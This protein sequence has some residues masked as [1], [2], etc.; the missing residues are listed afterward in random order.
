MIG[1]VVDERGLNSDYERYNVSLPFVF[2]NK[3]KADTFLLSLEMTLRLSY[4]VEH[5]SKYENANF[6]Y[7]SDEEKEILISRINQDLGSLLTNEEQEISKPR[8]IGD[9]SNKQDQDNH[10]VK[11]NEWKK[12]PYALRRNYLDTYQDVISF[13]SSGGQFVWN[14]IIDLINS[15]ERD[16]ISYHIEEYEIIE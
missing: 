11:I 15:C 7:L 9:S 4:V 13:Y 3:E 16:S 1:Y 5:S 2:L 10:L 6:K 12:S 14:E 8:F